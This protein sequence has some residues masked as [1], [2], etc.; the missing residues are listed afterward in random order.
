M[1]DLNYSLKQLGER[2]RDGSIKTQA[3][4]GRML[5]LI[6]NQLQKSGFRHLKQADQLRT[7]HVTALVER[8]QRE[9]LSAGTMK[10]RL[11]VMRWWAEK[12]GRSSVIP[13][14]NDK[15]GIA[16]RV[17]VSDQSKAQELSREAL[18]KVGDQHV[19]M[20]LELQAAFGLRREAS[21]KFIPNYA[22]KGDRIVLKASWTKGGKAREIPIRTQAQ[23]DVLDRAHKL[24]AG[25]SLVPPARLYVQQEKIY[26]RH[27]VRAGLF[28]MHG[29]RHAYAQQRYNELMGCKCPHQGG[30][31]SKELTPEMKAKDHEVRLIISRELGHEREQI[32]AQ[33]IGR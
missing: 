21:M 24:A 19:R 5:S 15:L 33:Y 11:S 2:N 27:C 23:R 17:Y 10:N 30:P 13:R 7:K 26:E 22:D 20:S 29:L 9:E 6:A 32:I 16:R 31:K 3:Q 12:V 28:K 4:R 25:G 1:R 8:W 18:A 14:D